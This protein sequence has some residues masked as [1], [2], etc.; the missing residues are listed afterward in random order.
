[1]VAL[2]FLFVIQRSEYVLYFLLVWF[3]VETVVLKYAPI[4][5]YSVLKYLPEVLI[6]GLFV[7]SCILY[8]FKKGKLWVKN[9]LNMWLVGIVTVAFVSLMV[10][11]YSPS[12]WLLGL[13]QTLRYVLVFFV[14]LNKFPPPSTKLSAH[15]D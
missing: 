3:P 5:Y 2:V 10:N 4:E 6:Y 13:R 9:P 1:M 12:I 15:E 14:V 11:Q 7:G 8:I